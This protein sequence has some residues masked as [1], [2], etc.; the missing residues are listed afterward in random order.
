MPYLL[1]KSKEFMEKMR[2]PKERKYFAA[3][4]GGKMLGVALALLIMFAASS[5]LGSGTKAHAQDTPAAKDAAPA[6]PA[7]ATPAADAPKDAPAA[8]AAPA[9]DAA[10]APAAPPPPNPPYVNPIN[11]MW[12]LIA[13]FLVFFMQAGFMFL[14]AGFSRT[15][16]SVNVMLEGLVDTSLCG[17]LFYCWGFAWMFGH[18]NGFIG[19]GDADG[20]SWYCL[21]NLPDTYE[22]TGV[23]TLAIFLFQ[24][25]FADTCSTI[26]SGAMV[27]RT[28]FWGDLWYS[29][30]VSGFIYPIFGHWAWGP[31]GW[32]NTIP[33]WKA[34]P[35]HDFAGSTVV[36]TIGG[37]IALAG[38]IVLGPRLGRKF[39]RDGGGPM[40]GHN[41]LIAAVGAII[42][43]FGWYGFNPGSTLSAM[44]ILGV[45]RVATNTTL[46]ACTGGLSAL[47]FGLSAL[48][49]MGLRHDA[50]WF[51][52]R[53]R[54][55]YLPLLLG[56]AFRRDDDWYR[57]RRARR[58]GHRSARASA[59]RRSLRRVAR[60]R[61]RA[62]IYRG[63]L[64]LGLFAT[65]QFGASTPTGADHFG[66][67]FGFKGLFYGGGTDQLVAQCIG[68]FSIGIGVFITAMILMYAVKATGTLRVSKEGEQEGLD[69]HEHEWRGLL[70]RAWSVPTSNGHGHNHRDNLRSKS[71]IPGP[72]MRPTCVCDWA[73]DYFL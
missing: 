10:A 57:G 9:A 39:V 65:G 45:A 18:G 62:G 32:L 28:G 59:H 19:H 53:A 50:Q 71:K 17:I 4:L 5:Y 67:G 23:A 36:H 31:D 22:S 66:G 27:G 12:V 44:D 24:F 69:L 40:P 13:A 51:A 48:Q 29:L 15:R 7:A 14:E 26:T 55:D 37:M 54:G 60:P 21:Q 52:R 11:T 41:M 3:I 38:A 64:S 58:A 70:S 73:G 30:G 20:H 8:P 63:T 6:T 33:F 68:N 1:N 72:V 35:F 47:F 46:A 42:L 16:E 25:A 56:L 49:E 61:S 43:W 34:A 2:D